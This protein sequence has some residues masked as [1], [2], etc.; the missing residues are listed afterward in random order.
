MGLVNQVG[1]VLLDQAEHGLV[2]LDLLVH[3]DRKIGFV[4][5]Q[6]QLLSFCVLVQGLELLSLTEPV[7]R[8]SFS[9]DS[10]FTFSY[11]GN[12]GVCDLILLHVARA[13]LVG[14]VPLAGRHIHLN[15]CLG[16]AGA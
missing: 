11:L 8:R 9:P 2:L 12:V 16:I 6:V 5:R 15:G 14:F 13:E 3:V 1:M 10:V 4:H 7:R